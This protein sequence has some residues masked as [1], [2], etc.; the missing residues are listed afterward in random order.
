ML[1]LTRARHHTRCTYNEYTTECTRE[2]KIKGLY[3]QYI[4]IFRL[5]KEYVMYHCTESRASHIPVF[6]VHVIDTAESTYYLR[7]EKD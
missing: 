2:R 7:T 5:M 3:T 4:G 1:A 6:E